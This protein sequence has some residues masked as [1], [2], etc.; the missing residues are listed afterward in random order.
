MFQNFKLKRNHIIIGI[1]TLIV[2]IT[3]ASM[4]RINYNENIINSYAAL[5][6]PLPER[7]R[8]GMFAAVWHQIA[9]N[10]RSRFVTEGDAKRAEVTI[11]RAYNFM[12]GADVILLIAVG[13]LVL[14]PIVSKKFKSIK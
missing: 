10:T 6:N 7:T 12:I 9:G 11:K 8:I 14:Q 4:I 1:C 5:V 3:G 2:I 13:V